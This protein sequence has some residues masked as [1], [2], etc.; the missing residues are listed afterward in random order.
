MANGA[1]G[2]KGGVFQDAVVT[3]HG[4][5]VVMQ[6]S[7]QAI[8]GALPKGRAAQFVGAD[9]YAVAGGRSVSH[10]HRVSIGQPLDPH[11][12]HQRSTLG[13]A[14]IVYRNSALHQHR[15]GADGDLDALTFRVGGQ[16]ANHMFGGCRPGDEH[17]GPSKGARCVEQ[18]GGS[19]EEFNIGPLGGRLDAEQVRGKVEVQARELQADLVGGGKLRELVGGQCDPLDGS[20]DRSQKFR[21]PTRVHQSARHSQ[22]I[23]L[24]QGGQFR[25][26]LEGSNHLPIHLC[27]SLCKDLRL[28]GCKP[29][30]RQ[31]SNV[32]AE[33][34]LV[35]WGTGAHGEVP[36]CHNK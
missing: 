31:Q 10:R 33:E 30:P 29:L 7:E 2:G 11:I 3:E 21:V 18:A 19:S 16:E 13:A 23:V 1:L 32:A 8:V 14:L 12:E 35:C 36:L 22:E 34:F 26:I 9:L 5:I 25:A 27:E 28:V 15:R 4:L 24:E 20:C 6:S 17:S